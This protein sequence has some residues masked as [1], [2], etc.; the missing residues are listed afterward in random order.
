MENRLTVKHLFLAL[1]SITAILLS[2]CTKETTCDQSVRSQVKLKFYTVSDQKIDSTRL[3]DVTLYGVNNDSMIYYLADN[4]Y[5]VS[6]PLSMI[7]DSCAFVMQTGTVSDTFK[8][9]YSRDLH[10]TSVECGFA[11][12]FT[13]ISFET[14]NNKIDSFHIAN[15]IVNPIE[16]ENIKIYY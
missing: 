15:P 16:V 10:F 13:I 14:T 9:E 5:S 1:F 2:S 8:F 3:N 4:L 6:L 12:S 11:D 7:Q